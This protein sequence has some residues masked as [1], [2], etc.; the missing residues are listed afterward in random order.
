[1]TEVLPI[2]QPHP[3][4][5]T[6]EKAPAE[7]KSEIVDNQKSGLENLSKQ[8]VSGAGNPNARLVLVG[9]ALES[10]E[11]PQGEP[12]ADEAGQLLDRILFA[13]QLS[14][15]EVYICNIAQGHS[16]SESDPQN[17]A[18]KTCETYLKQQLNAISPE[19]ILS[20]GPFVTQSML[21]SA[22]PMGK[23]RGRWQT[24][25]GIPLM[26]TFDPVYLLQNPA[27][28]HQVWEDIKQVIH[29]LQ[30]VES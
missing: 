28:K 3:F 19:I 15:E 23:L 1:V 26:P 10:E 22:E 8:M 27:G 6:T 30:D 2:A 14:R 13:M 9:E 4:E 12:C 16:L 17:T 11:D 7:F 25:A 20:L 24:Y 21:K 5:T 18:F 29:R